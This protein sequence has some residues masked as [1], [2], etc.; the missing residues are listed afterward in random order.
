VI[1]SGQFG[2][3]GGDA[4]VEVFAAEPLAVALQREDLA[5]MDEPVDHRGGGH[6][7]AEDLAPR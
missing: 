1:R 2:R 7:V 4:G 3:F 6:V 5:V